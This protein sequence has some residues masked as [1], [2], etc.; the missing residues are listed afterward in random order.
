[1]AC[2]YIKASLQS[3]LDNRCMY[4]RLA[5]VIA[6]SVKVQPHTPLE[7]EA[8]AQL[9]WC[10]QCR[11]PLSPRW[12]LCRMEVERLE[13]SGPTFGSRTYFSMVTVGT[14][15]FC[16]GGRD[17]NARTRGDL[18]VFDASTGSWAQL[19]CIPG[20]Q[21]APR[22]S[23]TYVSMLSP[24]FPPLGACQCHA[25][26]CLCMGCLCRGLREARPSLAAA[27]A[28]GQDCPSCLD[29]YQYSAVSRHTQRHPLSK[30]V[31]PGETPAGR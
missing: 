1:M 24:L 15:C 29:L 23:H 21:P 19:S 27:Q 20:A 8:P 13:P 7:A 14:R 11:A 31:L 6:F 30:S 3:P 2:P 25:L 17:S 9:G 16:Y 26:A 28:P 22:S 4:G 12:C 18:T 5:A 10:V